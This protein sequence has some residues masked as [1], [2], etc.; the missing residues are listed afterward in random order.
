MF[1]KYNNFERVGHSLTDIFDD[2]HDNPVAD[3]DTPFLTTIKEA[4][5]Q[6]NAGQKVFEHNIGTFLDGSTKSLVLDNRYG[7][8][9]NTF[10]QTIHKRP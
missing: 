8:G 2:G 6:M 1:E 10:M 5:D 3:I 9:R 4:T 7:S